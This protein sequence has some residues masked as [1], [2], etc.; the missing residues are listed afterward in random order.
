MREIRPSGSEGG[1]A[2]TT[3]SL[4]LSNAS[5]VPM[6]AC[7]VAKRLECAASSR[8]D[9]DFVIGPAPAPDLALFG[10]ASFPRI[11]IFR[12]A[13]T[14]CV[15]MSIEAEKEKLTENLTFNLRC[16][17]NDWSVRQWSF[18]KPRADQVSRKF[19]RSKLVIIC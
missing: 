3:P 5:R 10:L 18:G 1:V 7:R 13:W 11:S 8:F 16:H 12:F 9:P 19:I 6:A 17:R 4:P 2:R 15:R 14:P